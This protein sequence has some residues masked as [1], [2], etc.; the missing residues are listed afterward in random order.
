[1]Q[2]RPD[3][4]G[5]LEAAREFLSG[6][7]LDALTD[8]RMRFRVRIAANL[9]AIAQREIERGAAALAAERSRLERLLPDHP[10]PPIASAESAVEAFNTVLSRRLREGSIDA[11][12]GSAVWRH[13]V[14]TTLEKLEIANPAFLE[15]LAR[16][17][18]DV[19]RAARTER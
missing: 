16:L 1:M 11:S 13:V 9:L 4:R 14:E 15:R 5:L 10:T 6:E 12:V 7:L 17:G 2:D 19:A 8:E 3:V 18:I